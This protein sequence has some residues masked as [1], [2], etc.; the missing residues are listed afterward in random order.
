MNCPSTLHTEHILELT[1]V[2]KSF[3]GA[4]V[5]RRISLQFSAGERV[6]L[7]GANGAGKS[8]LMR[9][10][11]SLSRPDAGKIKLTRAGRVSFFSHQLFLYPR[12]T[13]MENLALFSSLQGANVKLPELLAD[14]GLE[15]SAATVVA[16]LSKGNQ[17]RV[18][19]ARTF[20]VPAPV[21]LLDEPTS[22][23]DERGATQLLSSIKSKGSSGDNSSVVVVATH[24]I[25]R[26][27]AWANR[28]IVLANGAVLADS[29]VQ[30]SSELLS[31]TIQVYRESNR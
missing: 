2:S 22:N 28:I 31:Q 21:F 15:Q 16:S 12:L 24:D 7:L 3:G 1:G 23:L 8:T 27:G 29:G 13:V 30:A 9:I 10:I 20:L 5:L 19:L 25:H 18:A 14:W 4:P 6:L 17:A 11:S 26:L